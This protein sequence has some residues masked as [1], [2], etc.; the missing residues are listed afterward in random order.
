MLKNGTEIYNYK[1]ND[2]IYYGPIKDVSVLNGGSEYDVI[3]PPLLSLS[4]GSA[5]IEPVIVGSL[6]KIYIDPQD[7]DI[8][9]NVSI[10]LTGGN[11]YGANFEP[12]IEKYAREIEFD[13]RPLSNGGGLDI[14][15]EIISFRKKHHLIDGQSIIYNSNNND[16][17]GIGTF[18][19]SNISQSK[20]LVNNAIYYPEIIN[21]NSIKIYSSYSDYISGINT[22]GFTTVA[23]SGIH[24]FKTKINN[25][26]TSIK[27]IDGG[28]GYAHRNLIVSSAGISTFNHTINFKNHGFLD[29][30][31]VTYNYETSGISGLS[32]NNQY[33]ILRVDSDRFRIC[34]AG[35]GGTNP[36]NYQRKNYVKFSSAGSGY[37]YFSYPEIVLSINYSSVGF[38]STQVKGVIDSTPIIRGKI[39]QIYVYDSGNNYGSNV[40]NVHKRPKVIIKN[41]KESKFKPRIEQNI[42]QYPN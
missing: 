17:I 41:G 2:K 8:D 42:I 16:E 5:L 20:T 29:G 11:G 26:L 10:S 4:Y 36:D 32:T 18:K 1:S 25:K 12:V 14:D 34:N 6:E 30:E 39:T 33:K 38:G 40:L 19:G 24:K 23:N 35:V 27:I 7:F 21:D 3:N 31:I 15:N 9:V 13:A 22:V 28:K 37:Q